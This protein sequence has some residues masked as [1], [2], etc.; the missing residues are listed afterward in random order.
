MKS[1]TPELD[2]LFSTARELWTVDLYQFTL[3]DGSIVRYASGGLTVAWGGATWQA[4]GPLLSRGEIVCVRGMEASTLQLTVAADTG[5]LLLTLPWLQAVCNGALD[6]ARLLVL[7]AYAPAPGQ[8]IV[9]VLHGFEGRVGDIDADWLEAR[10]EV[11]SDLEL[12]DTQIPTHV[13]QS[14][15][16]FALYSQ[17]CGVARA[18]YQIAATVAVGS[19]ATTISTG[20]AL[21]DGWFSGGKLIFTS[22]TNAGAQRT[23]KLHAGG[24]LALSYPLTHVPT[25]GDA[26]T[27]WPGCDH[28]QAACQAKFNNAI[29]FG[30]QPYIPS[31]LTTT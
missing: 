16:R 7:H 29:R 8:A 11:K 23:I 12:F 10:I 14:A 17:G 30:G 1:A 27:L 9:G 3:I 13:Y 21:P 4:A 15:C 28:T 18:A 20:L 5:H 26:F 22:G 31:A 25:V 19:D 6:G 24:A 2:T